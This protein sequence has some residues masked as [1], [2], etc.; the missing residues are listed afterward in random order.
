MEQKGCIYLITCLVNGKKYVG[1]HKKPNPQ[2]R[3]YQHKQN[4][5]NGVHGAFYTD[6]REYGI[7]KFEF[8]I[9]YTGPLDSLNLMELYFAE[10]HASYVWDDNPGGYNLA[11]CG[12]FTRGTKADI[13]K[14][15]EYIE[16]EDSET[17][18]IAREL[19]IQRRTS[20]LI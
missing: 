1:Q 7:D 17:C 14:V 6:A 10:V 2:S 8:D 15:K 3:W 19:S 9:V 20:L 18:S 13:S 11:M 16:I 4:I 12:N 5:K